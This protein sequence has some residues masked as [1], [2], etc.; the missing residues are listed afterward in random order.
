MGETLKSK[1]SSKSENSALV[2]ISP[3]SPSSLPSEAKTTRL[4]SA[5]AHPSRGKDSF[6]YPRQ[7]SVDTPSNK[8]SQPAATSSGVSLLCSV[9]VEALSFPAFAG[10]QTVRADIRPRR[11][12]RVPVLHTMGTVRQPP[13]FRG[14][15][16]QSDHRSNCH[17]RLALVPQRAVQILHLR[18]PG[19]HHEH[20]GRNS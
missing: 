15:R 5:I 18:L 17:C 12:K 1:S 8:R 11:L 2:T 20:H 14:P 9:S 19:A 10:E 3:P 7:P 4:P 16:P 6:R 13:S